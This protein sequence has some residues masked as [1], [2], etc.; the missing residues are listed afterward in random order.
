MSIKMVGTLVAVLAALV[1]ATSSV[2]LIWDRAHRPEPPEL[3]ATVTYY[4]PIIVTP[5][6]ERE[7]ETV[8]ELR[9]IYWVEHASVGEKQ[10]NRDLS[11]ES[12]AVI[13]Q[14]EENLQK[15]L[16]PYEYLPNGF[17]TATVQNRGSQS[18]S[19]V[20]LR[21]PGA[22]AF[23]WWPTVSRSDKKWV[24]GPVLTAGVLHP[25]EAVE[26]VAFM[27]SEASRHDIAQMQLTH[28]RGVGKIVV[29]QP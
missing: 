14:I 24:D 3:V 28:L 23:R 22:V 25:L 11:R 29:N 17:I 12:W 18:V 2:I 20:Q 7:A 13:H 21:V 9:N 8:K 10:K 6:A 27:S 15:I 19:D 26:V 1:G 16:P 4:G 5:N